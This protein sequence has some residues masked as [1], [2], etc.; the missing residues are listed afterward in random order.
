MTVDGAGTSS[1]P[2]TSEGLLGSFES[3]DTDA[4]HNLIFNTTAASAD[5]WISINR[6]VGENAVSIA[7]FNARGH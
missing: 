5:D 2:S 4:V 3:L 7:I 6:V 1:S